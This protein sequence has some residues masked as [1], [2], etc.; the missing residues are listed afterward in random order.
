MCVGLFG[1]VATPLIY[2]FNKRN[3][4]L[5]E[6]QQKSLRDRPGISVNEP[7]ISHQR[8][9]SFLLFYLLCLFCALSQEELW[10]WIAA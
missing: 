5:K 8:G 7:K 6:K 9:D 4:V 1:F 2:I 3:S 10:L